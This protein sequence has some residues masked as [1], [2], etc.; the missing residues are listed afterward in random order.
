AVY[1]FLEDEVGIR[2]W[3][4][5]ATHVPA[6]PTLTIPDQHVRYV[7][8]LEYRETFWYDA[9]VDKDWAVRN[10]NNG[11][12]THLDEERGGCIRY[13]GNFVHTFAQLVNPAEHFEEHPEWFAFIDGERRTDPAPQRTGLCLTNPELREFLVQQV[14]SWLDAHPG[15]DII[16]VSQND[17]R[18]YCHCEKCTA[19]EQAEGSPAGPL[20]DA[21]NYVAERVAE[22]YPDV[23]VDT[24]AYQYTRKPPAHIRPLPNVIVRLCSIECSYL[25]PLASPVNNT[26][27]DDIRGWSKVCQRLYIWDY[28]TNFHHYLLPHPNLRVLGPNIRFFVENGVKGVFEQGAYHSYGAEFAPL[29]SWVIARLLWN[30]YQDDQALIEEFVNGYYGAAAEPIMRYITLLHDTAEEWD[31][32]MGCY[33]EPTAP[34][35]TLDLMAQAE[36]LF[37][38]AEAAVAGDPEILARVQVARLPI[39]YVWAFRWHEFRAQA[40]REGME[41]PGP[42]DYVGNVQEFVRVAEANDVRFVGEGGHRRLDSFVNRTIGLGRIASPPP[43]GCEELAPDDY[44]DLQD[45]SFRL[46]REGT[47]AALKHDDLASDKVAAR[48]GGEHRE[49]AVQQPTGLAGVQ[50]DA[51]YT[52]YASIRCQKKGDEGPAFSFGVYDVANRKSVGHGERSCAEIQDDQYHTI[53]IVT[54]K[55]HDQMYIW[56]APPQNP[57]NVEA[58]WVDRIWLVRRGDEQ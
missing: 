44:I 45:N 25:Q 52:V 16:S 19:L 56:V 5:T 11:K 49:W 38:Q 18:V 32:F 8:P 27:G 34:F 26:F 2:W 57:D 51:T 41:W 35:L 3:T 43:P 47:W 53:E 7:P 12:Q 39:R 46:A 31:G 15:A 40:R 23:A 55:L 54:A 22:K 6:R 13:A 4:P 29:R 1:Q 17:S 58:V 10:K 48:M 24:L 36:K 20:L 9:F 30:P 37:D 42:D 28:T 21:V 33:V 14:F 50:P